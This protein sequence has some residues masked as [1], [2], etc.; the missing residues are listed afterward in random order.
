MLW[1][2]HT[3]VLKALI[4]FIALIALVVPLVPCYPVVIINRV[5]YL[6]LPGPSTSQI[7]GTFSRFSGDFL[8]RER[9]GGP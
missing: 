3:E 9:G 5:H 8:G 1:G 7:L 2:D 6:G 4:V